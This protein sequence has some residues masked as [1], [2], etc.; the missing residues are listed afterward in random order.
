MI[1]SPTNS[2]YFKFVI[3]EKNF[4]I[5]SFVKTESN[6]FGVIER[7]ELRNPFLETPYYLKYPEDIEK[8][9]PLDLSYSIAD[10]AILGK[11]NDGLESVDT[12]PKPGEKV[13]PATD[14][15]IKK[16]LD[17]SSGTL[18]ICTL[19]PN[20]IP[21]K[22]DPEKLLSKHMAI[23][24]MSGAG[25]SNLVAVLIEELLRKYDKLSIILFDMHGEYI[26]ALS[27]KFPTKF[28]ALPSSEI[29]IPFQELSIE[30]FDALYDLTDRVRYNISSL[31]E[32]RNIKTLE[33]AI[34]K[35]EEDE[36]R[37]I[38]ILWRLYDLKKTGLISEHSN[39]KS[40][41]SNSIKKSISIGIDFSDNTDSQNIA[42][43]AYII[44][45]NI[46][47]IKRRERNLPPIVIIIEEAHILAS[48][49]QTIAK[50]IL[51]RMAREGRKFGVFLI[52]V[53]QRPAYL[54]QTIMSQMNVQVFLRI[55]NPN[56][57]SNISS[58]AETLK[59][60]YLEIIPN[61]LPG[62]AIISGYTKYP[63]MVKIKKRDEKYESKA[64][65]KWDEMMNRVKDIE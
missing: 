60:N 40:F 48:Y 53:S 31:L 21:I 65:N 49:D 1:L 8:H 25:K 26:D 36:L 27:S 30:I 35:L 7:I 52:I 64:G 28:V 61:L 51:A 4:S 19:L 29:N 47:E 63:I 6:I 10:V 3:N 9:F 42:V 33:Q 56:D 14:E 45:S 57:L 12:P 11:Y 23:L 22:L 43:K 38:P 37:N 20:K 55:V 15:E 54:D 2:N 58:S 34:S 5:G 44:L 13:Y 18:D 59:K 41:I 46:L 32:N 62:E 50:R 24:A 17:L 16:A 39:I